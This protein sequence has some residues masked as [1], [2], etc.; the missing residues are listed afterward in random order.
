MSEKKKDYEKYNKVEA[1]EVEILE[2]DD[3]ISEATT[4]ER[5]VDVK[6]D[7]V[8]KKLPKKHKKGVIE[9][10]VIGLIGPDGIKS[11]G[12]RI[13]EEVVV[14]AIKNLV[15]DSLSGVQDAISA[16]IQSA[17]FGRD[18]VD[19]QPR[20]YRSTRNY[21]GSSNKYWSGPSSYQSRKPSRTGFGH[22]V[23]KDEV[24]ESRA[25]SDYVIETRVEAIEVLNGLREQIMEY[26][27]ARL[28]DYYSLMDIKST[29]YTDNDFGWT[30]LSK[31]RIQ[32]VRGGDVIKFPALEVL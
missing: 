21:G 1:V 2:K 29:N 24:P 14:P 25:L 31:A 30:D 5:N 32:S 8:V 20:D 3:Q 10:L 12:T 22:P 26:N 18:N 11:V 4:E 17:L 15:F 6:L 19:H 27:S 28:A 13:Q 23:D 16:S 9:R 7:S